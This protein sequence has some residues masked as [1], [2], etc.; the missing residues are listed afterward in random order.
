[1]NRT[2]NP[3]PPHQRLV[4][5]TSIIA[6]V[7]GMTMATPDILTQFWIA[8]APIALFGIAHGGIDP[9]LM[10][11]L[12]RI[13]RPMLLFWLG[14]YVGLASAFIGIVI[15]Q[16]VLALLLFL[17]LSIWHFGRSDAPFQ[18]FR[19]SSPVVWLSGSIPIIGPMF[20]HPEQTGQ[21]FAW[22]IGTDA[23]VVIQTVALIGP[24]LML[25][26]SAALFILWQ[27]SSEPGN[28]A[29]FIELLVLAGA[30]ILLPPI[31]AFTFYFCVVHSTRH[32]L[33]ILAASGPISLT[34]ERAFFLFRQAAPA[35]LL[36]LVLGIMVWWFL[37]SERNLTGMTAD[38]V[39]VLFWGLAALT[40][41]HVMV[42]ERWW[43]PG[44]ADAVIR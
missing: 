4:I 39:R 14:A 3:A 40:V 37:G 38:A 36:A 24:M 13:R 5:M 19:R 30:M 1:M 21:L 17:L 25:S 34:R 35:T 28:M 8:L 15:L 7:L 16:P 18:G 12:A 26:W 23:Q 2:M 27:Q 31:I 41:P 44:Q 33:D 10:N 20:G 11:R 32:F 29:G 22:M 42:V 9:W 43:A 6:A